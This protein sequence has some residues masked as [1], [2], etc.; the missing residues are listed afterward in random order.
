LPAKQKQSVAAFAG[1]FPA[2][3]IQEVATQC[4]R[5]SFKNVRRMHMVANQVNSQNVAQQEVLNK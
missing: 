1:S 2:S 4:K 3:E 5:A